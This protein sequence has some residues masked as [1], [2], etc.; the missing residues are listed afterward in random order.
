MTHLG[1]ENCIAGGMA[2]FGPL[3]YSTYGNHLF[4]FPPTNFVFIFFQEK[5]W[6]IFGQHILECKFDWIFLIFGKKI[7]NLMAQPKKG[8]GFYYYYY[9]F[10]FLR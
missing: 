9:Y 3:C 2:K 6:E 8:Q 10:K 5:N 1:L 7:A 4:F